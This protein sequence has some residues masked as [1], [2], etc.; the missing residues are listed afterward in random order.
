MQAPRGGDRGPTTSLRMTD[1][2]FIL[3]SLQG[4]HV[5]EEVGDL[6]LGE[7]LAEAGHFIATHAERYRLRERHWLACRSFL[8]IPS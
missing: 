4:M 5:G 6:L 8:N 1:F 7:D 3:L 2:I